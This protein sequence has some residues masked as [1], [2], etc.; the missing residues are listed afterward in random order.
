MVTEDVATDVSAPI[1]PPPPGFCQFSWPL[2][3][4]KWAVIR[5]CSRLMRNSLAGPPGV[6]GDCWLI[7]HYCR[8]RLSFWIAW[9]ILSLLRW[10]RSGGGDRC[11]F[12]D[13]FAVA[14]G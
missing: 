2:R 3:T 8:C 7:C 10:D 5:P 1:I 6:P 9:T 13:G 14:D 11:Q 12:T 4:G